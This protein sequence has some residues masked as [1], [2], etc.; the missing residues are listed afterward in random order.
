MLTTADKLCGRFSNMACI[1]NPA[2]RQSFSNYSF[3]KI[4]ENGRPINH[5][6][7]LFSDT[8]LKDKLN[9]KDIKKKDNKKIT[10][11]KICKDYYN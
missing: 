9:K 8:T 10:T 3:K 4:F 11:I 6:L 7:P 2:M 5:I 1:V